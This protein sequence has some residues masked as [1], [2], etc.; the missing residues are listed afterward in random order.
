M[1]LRTRSDTLAAPA[2]VYRASRAMLQ[3][4]QPEL[5]APQASKPSLSEAPGDP[6]HLGPLRDRPINATQATDT[7]NTANA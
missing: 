1:R 6:N 7:A 4:M 5:G 2:A 3:L